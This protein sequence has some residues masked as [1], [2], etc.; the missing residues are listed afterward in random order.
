H[1]TERGDRRPSV[2][3]GQSTRDRHRA[4][5]EPM[6]P[7]P[8]PEPRGT[9]PPNRRYAWTAAGTN[10][11]RNPWG[12]AV[13]ATDGVQPHPIEA[14]SYRILAERLDLERWPPIARAVV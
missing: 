1:P 10:R 9:C 12:R 7:H 14:E 3:R 8:R 6:A 4:R 5:T 13:T 2:P 11:T